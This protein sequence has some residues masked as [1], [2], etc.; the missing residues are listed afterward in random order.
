MAPAGRLRVARPATIRQGRERRS[1]SGYRPMPIAMAVTPRT[2]RS[3]HAARAINSG[4]TIEQPSRNIR[5]RRSSL[6][7]IIAASAAAIVIRYGPARQIHSRSRISPYSSTA[8]APATIVFNATTG[9]VHSQATIRSTLA[10]ARVVIKAPASVLF[11]PTLH[12]PS[13]EFWAI[14]PAC[15]SRLCRT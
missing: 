6:T 13:S 1:R 11:P 3:A 12:R 14:V 10:V 2:R 5:S 15:K 9:G 4:L 8:Q 7:A